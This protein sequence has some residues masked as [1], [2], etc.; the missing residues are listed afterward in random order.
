[1]RTSSLTPKAIREIVFE[2][3]NDFEFSME[4]E[5][6]PIVMYADEGHT[7]V[8]SDCVHIF[9]TWDEM[10]KA[11]VFYGKTLAEAAPLMTLD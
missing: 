3:Y 6:E 11:P 5:E 9:D 1:M 8:E 7:T 10:L 4:G 2:G